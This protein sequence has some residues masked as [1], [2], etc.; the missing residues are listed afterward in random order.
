MVEPARP[1]VSTR[2]RY[3]RKREKTRERLL[4]AAKQVMAET[5]VEAST[6]AEIAAVADVS[7]GTFYNYF[8][9]REEILDAVAASLVGEF[10]RVMDVIQRAVDDPAERIAVAIRL[11]LERVRDDRLW[12]WFMA[13]Y[14]PSLP[15]L[16]D[17]T[18]EI[19]RERILADGLRRRR[20]R[21]PST[22]AVGDLIAGTSVTALR[23][24]LEGRA[25]VEMATEV[26]ELVLR[27]L[28]VPL[29]EAHRI[30]NRPIPPLRTATQ[31]RTRLRA[32]ASGLRTRTS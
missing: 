29:G 26:A 7:P 4:Q 14:A 19:I 16:R 5:G 32:T 25:P 20:F 8:E 28:G 18:R 21:L 6:I 9:T 27:A 11:F 31:D 24:I 1:R 2:G 12:G 13:R 30:A 10:R 3:L 15:I 22:R 23:S 17:Q